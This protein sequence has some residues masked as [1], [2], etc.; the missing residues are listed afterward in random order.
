MSIQF[1]VFNAGVLCLHGVIK[2]NHGADLR[3]MDTGVPL[4]DI[5]LASLNT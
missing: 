4:N 1:S 2:L 5:H 3:K